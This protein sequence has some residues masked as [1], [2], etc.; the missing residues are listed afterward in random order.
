MVI[1][2]PGAVAEKASR[3]NV[4]FICRS[5]ED[6]EIIREEGGWCN[7][8]GEMGVCREGDDNGR[9]RRNNGQQKT[10]NSAERRADGHRVSQDLTPEHCAQTNRVSRIEHTGFSLDGRHPLFDGRI[11][12]TRRKA[13]PVQMR[14]AVH[15]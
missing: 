10:N 1:S 8:G 14:R 3:I 4:R 5:P 2:A 7:F 12:D 15:S 13:A 9:Q 11:L 6:P